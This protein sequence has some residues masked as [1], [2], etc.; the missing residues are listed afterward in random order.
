MTRELAQ[1]KEEMERAQRKLER[2]SQENRLIYDQ[3]VRGVEGDLT[4]LRSNQDVM[5]RMF[6]DEKLE[7]EKKYLSL[8]DEKKKVINDFE[9]LKK[10]NGTTGG[11]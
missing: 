1:Q 4:T 9:G 11:V 7:Y 8:Q 6:N 2:E 3:K 10:K 5:A